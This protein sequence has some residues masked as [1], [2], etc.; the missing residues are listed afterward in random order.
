MKKSRAAQRK[1]R[2]YI[3]V[4]ERKEQK[5]LRAQSCEWESNES[6]RE[7]ERRMRNEAAVCVRVRGAEKREF[8]VEA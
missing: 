7:I 8:E 4:D 5:L 1:L 6:E 3:R 2:R